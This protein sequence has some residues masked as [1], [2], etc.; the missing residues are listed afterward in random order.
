MQFRRFREQ[1]DE[2][3]EAMRRRA[4][5]ETSLFIDECLK[6]PELAPRIPSIPAGSGRFPPSLTQAFWDLILFR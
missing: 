4:C 1:K 5:A 2:S 3:F 6:R